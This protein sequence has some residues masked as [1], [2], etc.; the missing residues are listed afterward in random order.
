MKLSEIKQALK[1]TSLRTTNELGEEVFY[2]SKESLN[3]ASE[4]LNHKINILGL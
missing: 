4:E 2:F 1:Q 3:L